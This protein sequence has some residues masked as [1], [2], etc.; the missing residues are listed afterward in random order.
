[1]SSN[2]C[3]FPPNGMLVMIMCQIT[4]FSLWILIISLC[5]AQQYFA[6]RQVFEILLKILINVWVCKWLFCLG[7]SFSISKHLN[8]E[9]N[10]GNLGLLYLKVL[11]VWIKS[12]EFCLV[13]KAK[14]LKGFRL[15]NSHKS[16]QL[17]SRGR[18][19]PEVAWFFDLTSVPWYSCH[20]LGAAF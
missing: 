12:L 8:N 5:D 15:S 11:L 16:Q 9:F 18:N 6:A 7:L 17:K 10:P 1:M 13:L 14:F 4:F 19:Q 20:H 3:L 2:F